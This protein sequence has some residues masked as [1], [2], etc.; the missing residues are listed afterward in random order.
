[1]APGISKPDPCFLDRMIPFGVRDGN[2]LWVS[3]DRKFYFTWDSMHGEIEWY[4][5]HGYHLGVLDAVS[6]EIIKPAV[7]GR[8]I[9]I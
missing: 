4:N 8:K 3:N 6:G 7:R 9:D 5:K 1:M 2:K